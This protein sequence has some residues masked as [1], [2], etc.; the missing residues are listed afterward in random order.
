MDFVCERL[1]CPAGGAACPGY[2]RRPRVWRHLDTMQYPTLVRPTCPW[3]RCAEHGARHVRVPWAK[4]QSPFTAL[5]DAMVI[6][7]LKVARFT[8]EAAGRG[9]GVKRLNRSHRKPRA[10]PQRRQLHLGELDLYPDALAATR[11]PKAPVKQFGH[12]G[13]AGKWGE[14]Q[15]V[16]DETEEEH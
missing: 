6:D 7:W 14:R 1:F 10:V 4:T 11:I 15:S 5:F 16:P 13:P 12:R 2:D 3:V 8:A 9:L